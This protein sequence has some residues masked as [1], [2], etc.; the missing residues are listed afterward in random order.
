MFN[1]FLEPSDSVV[2]MTCVLT[3]SLDIL[4]Y[5]LTLVPAEVQVQRIGKAEAPVLGSASHCRGT[6]RGMN[7]R[8]N[9]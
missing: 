3:H 2:P 1:V 8:V 9:G 4:S 7:E 5:L 6:S